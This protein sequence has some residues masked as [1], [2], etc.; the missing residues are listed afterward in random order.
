MNA[1]IDDRIIHGPHRHPVAVE[2]RTL[3]LLLAAYLR[4]AAE[5]AIAGTKQLEAPVFDALR[6]CAGNLLVGV[7]EAMA[8]LDGP[9]ANS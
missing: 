2:L 4:Y 1:D 3:N 9:G 5:A 8:A 7:N 6:Q